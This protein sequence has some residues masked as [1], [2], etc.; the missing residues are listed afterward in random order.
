MKKI[1]YA[2]L[3]APLVIFLFATF[4]VPVALMIFRSFDD[5]VGVRVLPRTMQYLQAEEGDGLPSGHVFQSFAEELQEAE[6]S[7]N[8][9]PLATRLNFA[10]PGSRSAV[11]K[12][13]RAMRSVDITADDAKD[14]IVK[15]DAQWGRPAV[16]QGLRQMAS[17]YTDFFYLSAFDLQRDDA[18]SVT[19]KP[20][21][22]KLYTATYI[23]TLMVAGSVTLLCIVLA[24]PVA[25]QLA[26]LPAK[27]SSLLMILV[28]LPFWTAVLVRVGAWMV[29]LQK[30][31]VVNDV[32]VLLHVIHEN[33]RLELIYNMTGTIVVMTHIMLPF[34]ILPLYAVMKSIPKH[35]MR[36]GVSLG[37]SPI[38]AWRDVYFPL[39]VPGLGAG[40]TLVF[41]QCAGYYIVPALVGGSSGQM[42]SNSIA[43]HMQTS[44]NWGLAAALGTVL[45]IGVL[46]L[47]WLYTRIADVGKMRLG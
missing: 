5:P 29:L 28:L 44:L 35:Y 10:V 9:G 27:S 45:L 8:L 21:E 11:L 15:A 47:Y 12:A 1:H 42:I 17:G 30:N 38:Q 32:L 34:M 26:Q 4:T 16:W 43:Y 2:A 39:T 7:G 40:A 14:L 46:A 20:P 37:A 33:Q 23:R 22:Q 6:K 18:G 19:S 13:A 31:G 36:A 25:Y 3:V 24:Y 41:I